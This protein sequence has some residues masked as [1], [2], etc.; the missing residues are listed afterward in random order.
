MTSDGSNQDARYA[1]SKLLQRGMVAEYES[2]FFMRIKRVTGISE[3]LLNSFYIFGFKPLL[4]CALLRLAP[5]TLGE[6]FFIARIIKA[7]FEKIAGK[8]LHIKE[9]IDIV[10]SWPSEEASPVIKGSLDANEDIG[11]VV[12]SKA[13]DDVFDIGGG[14]ALGIGGDDYLGDAATDGG[15]DAVESGD[16]SILNSLIGHGSL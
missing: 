15:D 13:I 1:L 5:T 3:Y 9:K 14:E 12:V 8:K 2:E 10:L 16:I 7:R 11:V 6:A 4:Q